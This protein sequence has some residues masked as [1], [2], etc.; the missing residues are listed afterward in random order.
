MGVAL[1]RCMRRAGSAPLDLSSAYILGVK[2]LLT[3]P[4]SMLAMLASLHMWLAA[5]V[6]DI[7]VM[8]VC[9]YVYHFTGFQHTCSLRVLS[10]VIAGHFATL[11]EDDLAAYVRYV[12]MSSDACRRVHGTFC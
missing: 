3:Q 6:L 4:I 7:N 12:R 11:S 10:L 1:L 8:I 5:A 9:C 2:S